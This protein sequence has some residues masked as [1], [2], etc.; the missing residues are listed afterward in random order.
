MLQGQ[1]TFLS[2]YS[3]KIE[4]LIYASARDKVAI[5]PDT[6]QGGYVGVW[7]VHISLRHE[8]QI[9]ILGVD[10]D[11]LEMQSLVVTSRG[12][13]NPLSILPVKCVAIELTPES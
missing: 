7:H 9:P 4:S 13:G 8:D 3:P 10:N 12:D 1:A 5:S 2:A 11:I 6:L